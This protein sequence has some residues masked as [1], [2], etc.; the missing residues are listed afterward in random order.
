MGDVAPRDIRSNKDVTYVSE[1][2]SRQAQ[3]EAMYQ[4][5]PVYTRPDVSTARQQLTRAEQVLDFL[6]RCG[7]IPMRQNLK[8]AVG[9]WLFK[10]WA[11]FQR[12]KL[13]RY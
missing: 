1:S 3:E 4:V 10:S 13:L 11:A 12:A 2:L 9:C 8:S 5:A 7:P 6:R